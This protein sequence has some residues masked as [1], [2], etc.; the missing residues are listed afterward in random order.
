[1]R[2]GLNDTSASVLI[3]AVYRKYARVSLLMASSAVKCSMD[4][5][6]RSSRHSA[7]AAYI[8]AENLSY[9][10]N[11]KSELKTVCV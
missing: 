6:A 8:R 2:K 11:S 7:S 9:N 1:M 3:S 4:S 10:K 5:L